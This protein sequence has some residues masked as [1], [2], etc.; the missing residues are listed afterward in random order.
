MGPRRGW[1]SLASLASLI[2]VGCGGAAVAPAAPTTP[3][4]DRLEADPV[5]V[6]PQTSLERG[7]QIV[8]EAEWLGWTPA[9]CR[10]AGEAFEA[11]R[12]GPPRTRDEASY[13]AGLS[14]ARCGDRA[15]AR[16]ALSGSMLERRCGAGVALGVA[17]A[18][19]GE[20][21]QARRWLRLA[22]AHHPQCSDAWLH[23][24][25]V[26][27][28]GGDLALAEEHLGRALTLDSHD[29][30]ALHELAIVHLARA[31]EDVR[32]LELAELVCRQ[33]EHVDRH[34]APLYN[35]WGL[36]NAA[37]GRVVDAL[38]RFERA[39]TLDERQVEAMLNYGQISL[40]FRNF[41]AAE[42]VFRMALHHSPRS[43]DAL[44][45]LGVTLRGQGR[46]AAAGE[47]YELALALDP[48]RPEAWFN[49]GVLHQDHLQPTERSLAD[50]GRYF[51]T[52]LAKAGD[53]TRF[54]AAV[55]EVT[56]RCEGSRS[57]CE[58]GRIETL[59][60]MAAR[61]PAP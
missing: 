54:E 55:H 30:R 44:I 41:D 28:R 24:A 50:A 4:P 42:R 1:V 43:Y 17:A 53:D 38:E 48:E 29:V 23:L 3:P 45:G 15:A 10:R 21:D 7:R 39:F 2:G 49:L 8:S 37:Q 56:R 18:Q 25:I 47:Q 34:H 60:A 27:R 19:A 36:V 14:S 26:S 22:A 16:R 52:F 5:E 58:P 33:A 51:E 12:L 31:D 13:L 35:T 57:P 61:L 11:A 20:L 9:R 32:R 59:E 46:I 40:S 6:A